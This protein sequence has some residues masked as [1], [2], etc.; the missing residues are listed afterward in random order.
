MIFNVSGSAEL[1]ATLKIVSG[2]DRIELA[3]G[4]YSSLVLS[5]LN[6]D[7][8]V[9]IIS[10]DTAN[11]AMFADYLQVSDSSG[12]IIESID[13][14]QQ[15]GALHTRTP[16]VS[17]SRA[18]D[19]E[20]RDIA[21]AGRVVEDDEGLALESLTLETG[22]PGPV[23]GHYYGT[24]IWVRNSS[25]VTLEKIDIT[26]VDIG[27]YFNDVEDVTLSNSHLHDLRRDGLN[28]IDARNLTISD[29]LFD[30]FHPLEVL[31]APRLT[32][33]PDFI[34]FWG[35]YA[36]FG[37]D[38]LTITGNVF[39]EG[40]GGWMQGI[41]GAANLNLGDND[42]H[43]R[44]VTIQDNFFSTSH[45]N[46]IRVSDVEGLD[47]QY[48]TLVPGPQDATTYTSVLPKPMISV[49][50]GAKAL[51]DGSYDFT[52]GLLPTDVTVSNNIVSRPNYGSGADA[53]LDKGL[54]NTLR[55][56]IGDNLELGADP[57]DADYWG[58]L[59]P[60]QQGG[61][62][63][64]ISGFIGVDGAGARELAPWLIEA[65]ASIKTTKPNLVAG[66]DG[67]DV[68]VSPGAHFTLDGGAGDDVLIGSDG[69]DI[70]IGGAGDDVLTGGGG[71]DVF[72]L[73][74]QP[75]VTAHDMIADLD[76]SEGDLIIL[77]D[78]FPFKFFSNATDPGND[79]TVT[80]SYSVAVL[81]T[82]GDVAEIAAHEQVTAE[83]TPEGDLRLRFDFDGDGSANYI[84]TLK[85]HGDMLV[86]LESAAPDDRTDIEADPT[87][88][89]LTLMANGLGEL[90]RGGDG[91]DRLSGRQGD[92]TLF[93]GA[94]D[95]N[96]IDRG[97]SDVLVGGAG[98]DS[99]GMSVLERDFGDTDIILDLD[100][101]AGDYIG[102]T[103]EANNNFFDGV[104]LQTLRPHLDNKLLMV[105]DSAGLAE[106]ARLNNVSYEASRLS[107][108]F[109]FDIDG[110][111]VS[112]RSIEVKGPSLPDIVALLETEMG[113]LSPAPPAAPVEPAA[114]LEPAAPRV[115][116]DM[117]VT[118]PDF[119]AD[120]ALLLEGFA[121][122][123][124]SGAGFE[125]PAGG[126]DGSAALIKSENDLVALAKSSFAKASALDSDSV[127]IVLDLGRAAGGAI[128][129]R[130]DDLAPEWTYR[131][132]HGYPGEPTRIGDAR[133]NVI[134]TLGAD[135]VVHGGL[136][137]D[138]ITD[139]RGDDWLEG[140]GGNDTLNGGYG[141][142]TMIGGAGA[143]TFMIRVSETE[144]G[145]HD[146]IADLD[147]ASGDVLVLT[148]FARGTFT[149][150]YYFGT[151]ATVRS[152][153]D[154]IAVC[155][156][157]PISLASMTD[158]GL[159][160][161]IQSQGG[162]GTLEIMLQAGD[163]AHMEGLLVG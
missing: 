145:D 99:F 146:L 76:F 134:Q 111:G 45:P 144:P 31:Q 49:T 88:A 72:S 21:V 162:P 77:S 53:Y 20:V 105:T 151:T 58:D 2:G 32:D 25:D 106:L 131:I 114:P 153:E 96:L 24:G 13:V 29:N 12:L 112:D 35:N 75:G 64:D 136:G 123:F 1:V 126:D 93:G 16:L 155:D 26:K 125:A 55:I 101:A 157:A 52:S 132:A 70:L 119:G 161:S 39:L 65:A 90:L 19:V 133:A 128:T 117:A 63:T 30:N 130:V 27:M 7:D 81:E 8:P 9:T 95:D 89:G 140:G 6:F 163:L 152:F 68:L 109:A 23:A 62:I 47:I 51:G 22:V 83:R 139:W 82:P 42:V 100:F 36:K 71:G 118:S 124:F 14:R 44:N 115:L 97:G 3:P 127:E 129:L 60:G 158:D 57:E 102:L 34:Q 37:V 116:E 59:F 50:T 154:L 73:Q 135:D 120:E 103:F 122:G 94:G 92:D 54:Y 18:E 80:K 84:L 147:F 10:A 141:S 5:R 33:H 159:I 78:G 143:D 137:D 79:L 41:T 142:D 56:F 121:P 38:G 69:R 91:N 108:A 86:D 87:A 148:Q 138:R 48:N 107:V 85:G 110:D 15:E 43:M 98:G 28:I 61:P 40:A 160:L 4:D 149:D 66:G 67:D 46:A 156:A 113:P 74:A 17:I 104:S 11:R 150:P